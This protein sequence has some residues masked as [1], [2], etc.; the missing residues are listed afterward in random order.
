MPINSKS[1]FITV[2]EEIIKKSKRENS[3]HCM[4]ADAIRRAVPE[5]YS[6]DV[7]AESIRFN[8]GETRYYFTTPS[9]VAQNI[10]MY[11]EGRQV[12]PFKFT[13]QNGYTAPVLRQTRAKPAPGNVSKTRKRRLGQKDKTVRMTRR[14]AGLKV[15]EVRQRGNV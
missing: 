5:A 6:V 11:D 13:L 9:R 2:P 12:H 3:R 1:K 15:I 7:T 10:A 8:V 4:V 14:R